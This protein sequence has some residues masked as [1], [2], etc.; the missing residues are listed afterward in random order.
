MSVVILR[1]D[2]SELP[3]ESDNVAHQL[4]L[5]SLVVAHLPGP[6]DH[7]DSFHP[8]IACEL[9]LASKVVH[10]LDERGHNLSKS[11]VSLGAE[12]VDH[13]LCEGLAET[14]L[15]RNTIG[16]SAGCFC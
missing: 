11:G 7:L 13:L 3:L 5:I 4:P 12:R 9:C 2:G 1:L 16:V 15:L 8:L 10:V 14:L 6:V